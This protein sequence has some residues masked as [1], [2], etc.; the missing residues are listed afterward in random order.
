MYYLNITQRL[1]VFI[2]AIASPLSDPL[3][4]QVM[5]ANGFFYF[6]VPK[7]I[8]CRVPDAC[9]PRHKGENHFTFP[10]LLNLLTAWQVCQLQH[11]QHFGNKSRSYSPIYF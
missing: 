9:L 6:I 5:H 7:D 11:C 2:H 10:Y 8:V 4:T 1:I 3:Y